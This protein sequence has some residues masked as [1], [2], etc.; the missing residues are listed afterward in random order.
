MSLNVNPPSPNAHQSGRW[1][2]YPGDSTGATHPLETEPATT[3]VA[4][5]EEATSL[6]RLERSS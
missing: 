2:P 3:L 6:A 1:C 4:S 5:T